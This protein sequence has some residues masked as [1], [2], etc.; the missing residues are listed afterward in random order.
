MNH[1]L[2]LF[3]YIGPE[4]IV[5]AT[6]VLAAVGGFALAFGRSLTSWV[7]GGCCRMFGRKRDFNPDS[8]PAGD[9]AAK[10]VIK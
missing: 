10:A 6:S 1:T 8:A 2:L 7:A 5:P 9:M 3:A 4:T